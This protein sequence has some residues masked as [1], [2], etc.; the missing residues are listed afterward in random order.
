LAINTEKGKKR[1]RGEKK[2]RG[3]QIARETTKC[4]RG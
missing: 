1:M 3:G 2:R 4:E